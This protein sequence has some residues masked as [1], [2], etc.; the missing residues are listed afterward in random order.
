MAQPGGTS[1]DYNSRWLNTLYHLSS[2]LSRC[3]MASQKP[4]QLLRSAQRDWQK[5]EVAEVLIGFVSKR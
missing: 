4:P 2:T 3:H 5:A 1:T